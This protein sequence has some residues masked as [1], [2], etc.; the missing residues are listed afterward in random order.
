MIGEDIKRTALSI[1]IFGESNV[2]KTCICGTFLGLDFLDEHLSTIGIEK[3]SSVIELDTGEKL[4]IK[5][6]DTAGQERFRNI[7]VATLKNSQASVVVFDLTNKNS[8]LLVKDWLKEIRDYSTKIPICLFGNKSDLNNREVTNEE[9]EEFCENES[10][11]Y[12]ETSA[13]ENKGIKEGFTKLANVAYN[14]LKNEEIK[15]GEK[16]KKPEDNKNKKK[17]KFC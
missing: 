9:I 13:K 16:L 1:S 3:L 10:L 5:L 12:F 8:F 4:K 15:K 17:K 11:T 2:G 7:S 14:L 6:W